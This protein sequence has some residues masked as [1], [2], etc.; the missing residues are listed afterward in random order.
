MSHLQFSPYQALLGGAILGAATLA[1]LFTL[2]TVTGISGMV[3]YLAHI[4]CPTND[5]TNDDPL[6]LKSVMAQATQFTRRR[7]NFLFVSGLICSGSVLIGRSSGP[8]IP[9]SSVSLVR[10][11]AAALLVEFG[12]RLQN[13]CTSGHGICGLSRLSVRSAAAVGKHSKAA[14]ECI[15]SPVS[16]IFVFCCFYIHFFCFRHVHGR[17]VCFFHSYAHCIG[18]WREVRQHVSCAIHIKRLL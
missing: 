13:G 3:N 5:V 12:A 15:R 8:L 10:T 11:V 1:R 4:A 14:S 7:E 16:N 9:E 6:Q 18:P 2:G 17:W